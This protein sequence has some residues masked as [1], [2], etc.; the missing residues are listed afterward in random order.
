VITDRRSNTDALVEL[1]V[2]AMNRSNRNAITN[3]VHE[4]GAGGVSIEAGNQDL[5][6]R[7][8]YRLSIVM[9]HL[10]DIPEGRKQSG[11]LLT[12]TDYGPSWAEPAGIRRQFQLGIDV[13]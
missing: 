3:F 12:A 11:Q 4:L 1:T 7:E 8:R 10:N 9:K 6:Q 13:T 5:K 2:H